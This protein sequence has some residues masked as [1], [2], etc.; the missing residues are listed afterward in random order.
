MIDVQHCVVVRLVDFVFEA[1]LLRGRGVLYGE[2][3]VTG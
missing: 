2:Q 1:A 3:Q